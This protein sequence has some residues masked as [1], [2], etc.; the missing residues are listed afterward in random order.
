MERVDAAHAQEHFL[1]VDRFL[2]T[3]AID[4]RMN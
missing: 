4:W 1:A 2:V 3:A